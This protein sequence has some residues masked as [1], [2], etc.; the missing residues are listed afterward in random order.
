MTARKIA[1]PAFLLLLTGGC[2][3]TGE[4]DETGGITAIRS[5]CPTVGVAAATG[6][7]TLFD[8]PASREAAAIDVVADMTNVRGS[9]SDATDD[10][11]TTVNFE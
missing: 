2:A 3:H 8:P 10:I 11:V 6:D 4:F 7:I 1:V 9:C 5:A